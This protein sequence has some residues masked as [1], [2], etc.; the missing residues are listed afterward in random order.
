MIL[1]QLAGGALERRTEKGQAAAGAITG[2]LLLE[3]GE[4]A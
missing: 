4:R 3:A 1:D 2:E